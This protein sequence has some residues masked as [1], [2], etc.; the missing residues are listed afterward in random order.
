MNKSAALSDCQK[1]R[2]VGI[3]IQSDA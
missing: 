1:W 2:K 3:Y